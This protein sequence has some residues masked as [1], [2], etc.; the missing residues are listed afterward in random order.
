LEPKTK[1]VCCWQKNLIT[2]GDF[3]KGKDNNLDYIKLLAHAKINLS[4][5]V[6]GK[7]ENGYHDLQMIMQT[8]SLCDEVIIEKTK[9]Q[10]S[11]E[12]KIISE[13]QTAAD[14]GI[15]KAPRTQLKAVSDSQATAGTGMTQASHTEVKISENKKTAN[16][17]GKPILPGIEIS[18]SHPYVPSDERNICYKAAKEFFSTTGIKN[19]GIKIKINKKIP[20]GAGLAGGSTNAAAVLKGLNILYNAG[21][22]TDELAQIG[23][24]CGADVPFCIYGGTCLA[25]GMG[26]KLTRLPTFKDVNL[27]VVMPKFSVSTAWVYKNYSIEDQKKH[28]DTK[29]LISAIKAKNVAKV[30]HGM[31]NVLESVTT[32]KYPELE[33]IKHMLKSFKALGSMMSGS[34]PAVFGIFENKQTASSAFSELKKIYKQV[35]LVKTTNGGENYGEDI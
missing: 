18:C 15:T 2:D 22:T 35:Y 27:V 30:A 11:A 28:P 29:M 25:E 10:K 5:D 16:E 26:E 9:P 20:V 13:S 3:K 24:K 19:T 7:F 4:L 23:L 33:E 31:R 32:V 12:L 21:L 34:G 6:I 17:V 8:I 1:D 14:T